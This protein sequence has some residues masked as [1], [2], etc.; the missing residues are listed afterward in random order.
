MIVSDWFDSLTVILIYSAISLD[1][2]WTQTKIAIS[3][4]CN[5]S[6]VAYQTGYGK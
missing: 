4:S 6:V 3:A 5:V 1:F 2:L